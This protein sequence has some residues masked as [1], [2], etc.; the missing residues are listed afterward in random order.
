MPDA[1]NGDPRRYY[2]D[3]SATYEHRRSSNYHRML[4]DLEMQVA[5]PYALGARVLELGCGTGRILSRLAEIAEEAV[6]ID[7]SEG[8][9]AQAKA[10]GLDVRLGDLRALPF[11]DDTFDLTCS[12]KVLAHVPDVK[13]AIREAARVTRPGGHLV[14]ELYNPWSLRYLAKKVA[15][16]RPVGSTQ[17][18]ADVFT[19]WD[20]PR[21]VPS[22]LPAGVELV[23]FHGVRVLTPFAALHGIP[24]FGRG[25]RHA[26]D[27]AARSPL[28]YFG[29]FS[30]LT[31][32]K[33]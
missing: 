23:N 1:P 10:R 8:M 22:L 18:E 4:D 25:L 31:L 29:G 6:G 27:L 32:R 19:R 21:A 16:P 15:G 5:E 9:A 30:I 11:E 17:T 14:L 24:F 28:R 20:S 13:T 3:L 7:L 12:F 2:D 33:S 26:E